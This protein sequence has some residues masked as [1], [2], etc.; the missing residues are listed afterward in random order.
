MQKEQRLRVFGILLL[1]IAVLLNMASSIAITNFTIS[2]S[3]QSSYI[4]VPMLMGLLLIL[5]YAKDSKLNVNPKRKDIIIAVLLFA[6]YI[7]LLSYS[8]LALSYLFM[9]YR[10]DMLLMPLF[11]IAVISAIFGVGAIN[12]FK[13]LIVYMLFSSPIILLPI[14]NLSSSFALFN[15]NIVY[16][17]LRSIGIPVISNG[18]VITAP[19]NYSISIA[20]TCVDIGAFVALILFLI[21]VAY[22]YDGGAKKK[23]LWVFV[24]IIIMLILNMLRMIFIAIFWAYYGITSA[25]AIVHL[26]I[27]PLLFYLVIIIMILMAGRFGLH[28]Q[29]ATSKKKQKRQK[30]VSKNNLPLWKFAI[31]PILFGLIGLYFALPYLSAINAGYYTFGQLTNPSYPMLDRLILGNLGNS[32]QNITQLPNIEYNTVYTIGDGKNSTS[33]IYTIVNQTS[34]P[35]QDPLGLV[36]NYSTSKSSILLNSGISYRSM[37]VYSN[38]REFYINF[39]S[40]PMNISNSTFSI[41]Y[42]FF[43]EVSNNTILC[44]YNANISTQNYIESYIYN[45]LNGNM[46]DSN[47]ILCPSLYVAK[48]IT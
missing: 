20:K 46:G 29:M 1:F 24:S 38:K 11:I 3:N 23:L 22:L 8:R 6:A 21:P 35:S 44:Q 32:R 4:I 31:A 28:F 30:I 41:R 15:A 37:V 9:T 42:G 40:V 48:S 14:L 39:F 13:I 33:L 26:F 2:D 10:I 18:I 7:I 47:S 16:S 34:M 19:S 17:I 12:R 45:L 5:F 43:K 25:I 36:Y 27:G